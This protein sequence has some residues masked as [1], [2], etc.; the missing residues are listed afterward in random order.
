MLLRRLVRGAG[1]FGLTFGAGTLIIVAVERA[2][3]TR[4]KVAA[5]DHWS[6][7]WARGLLRLFAVDLV[8]TGDPGGNRHGQGRVVVANHRSIIDI[9]VVL[10]L[11]GGAMVSRKDLE[12]WPIIG[13]AASGA[14]TIFVDRGSKE[15]GAQAVQAME[16]S[17][18]QHDTVCIFPEGTTFVD[19]EVRP[20]KAGG[21][22]AAMRAG[23]PV[24]PVAIV[25]PSGSGAA[26]GGETFL[27]HLARLADTVRTRVFVEIGA[28]MTPAP[29]EPVVAFTERVR[30]EVDRLMATGRART[31]RR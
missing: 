27:R 22:V 7:V 8:V 17:L 20:F 13:R 15:S 1:F 9:A 4:D 26:F 2:K 21:F 24:V 16:A 29:D 31:D 6:G 5:R 14:G 28:P 30:V 10:S 23:V 25:Y 12:R 18:R 11:F 3:D 19:D